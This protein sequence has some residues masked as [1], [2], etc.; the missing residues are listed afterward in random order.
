MVT[1]FDVVQLWGN[2]VVGWEFVAAEVYGEHV[3]EDKLVVWEELSFLTGLCQVPF[4]FMGDFNEIV[5]VDERQ[6]ATSLPRST[7]EFKSWIYD[8]ELMDLGLTDR[9]FTWFRAQSCS[10]MDRVLVSLEWLEEFSKTSLQ[11]DPRGLSDHCPMIMNVTRLEGGPRPFRSLDSWFTHDGFLRMVK[12]E[13]RSTGEG[14]FMDKLKALTVPLGRWHRDHFG[15]LDMRINKFE[16][17]I[18]KVDDMVSNGVYDGTMEARR[19]ALVST[20]KKWYIRKE[21]HWK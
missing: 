8:M 9:R 13:W 17:K 6:G 11:G 15:N 5:Q 21:I 1:K 10:R 19:K 7:V 14:Q 18:K 3:R 2:D 20:C 12:E 4:C 16:E